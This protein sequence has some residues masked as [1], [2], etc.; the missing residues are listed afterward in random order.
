MGLPYC[1]VQAA[2]AAFEAGKAFAHLCA[3]HPHFALCAVKDERRLL[4]DLNKLKSLGIRIVE[5][6][7]DDLNGELTAFA[8]E[9]I[10]GEMR[11]HFRNFQLLK[12]VASAA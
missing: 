3:D 5:W 11:H 1:S 7:E 4:H 10:S 8:T 9:P 12:E 6:R 2:H